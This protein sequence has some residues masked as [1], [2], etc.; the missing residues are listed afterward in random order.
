MTLA[1]FNS[2]CTTHNIVQTHH[3]PAINFTFNKHKKNHRN[4]Q[5]Y[6]NQLHSLSDSNGD[7]NYPIIP[8]CAGTELEP[9]N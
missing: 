1:K 7:L 6:V 4:I 2:N 9:A 8:T 5:N 3:I